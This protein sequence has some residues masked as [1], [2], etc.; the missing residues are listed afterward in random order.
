VGVSQTQRPAPAPA[1]AGYQRTFPGLIG[2][3]LVVVLAVVGWTLFRA[4]TSDKEAVP[5][6]T[7]EWEP[8]VQAAADADS[9]PVLA[10][11]QLPDG[12]RATSATWSQGN[13]H[14]HLGVL[15]DAGK[16]VGLE[17]TSGVS[18]AQLVAQYVDQDAE[19][20]ADTTVDGTGWQIWTDAGGDYAVGRTAKGPD[21]RET[22]Y[23]VVGSA[24]PDR[25]REFAATLRPVGAGD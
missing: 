8:V 11:E 24:G 14:L 21:G 6:R 5:V 7:V 22:H 4:V 9:F 13:G 18:M 20:G 17:E 10:P 12:W 25:I 1:K 2:A 16:Y 3:M 23:L 15:T 19:K